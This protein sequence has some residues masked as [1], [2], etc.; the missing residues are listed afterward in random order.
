MP[1]RWAEMWDESAREGWDVKGG[2]IF[3]QPW[4]IMVL[5][6]R[7]PTDRSPA[8]RFQFRNTDT[9]HAYEMINI[10]HS[11]AMQEIANEVK[12]Q[13]ATMEYEQ[14]QFSSYIVTFTATPDGTI[15][16]RDRW[17]DIGERQERWREAVA[18]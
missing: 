15:T 5:Q 4:P 1:E 13:G 16:T 11:V 17:V 9:G 14:V 18:A 8:M 7:T 10:N 6:R 2:L 3:Q 12:W